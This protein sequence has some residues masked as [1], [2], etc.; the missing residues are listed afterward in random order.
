MAAKTIKISAKRKAMILDTYKE[1]MATET[2]VL[3]LL[4]EKQVK[5]YKMLV[6]CGL[7]HDGIDPAYLYAFGR[8]NTERAKNYWFNRLDSLLEVG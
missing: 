5:F 7:N 6:R 3:N 2:V 8:Q 4:Y 1:L